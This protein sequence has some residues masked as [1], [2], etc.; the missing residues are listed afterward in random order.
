MVI[1]I[2]RA[3]IHRIHI[4][5]GFHLLQK[6][7]LS[8]VTSILFWGNVDVIILISGRIWWRRERSFKVCFINFDRFY[9][10]QVQCEAVVFT[11]VPFGRWFELWFAL[12]SWTSNK[13]RILKSYRTPDMRNATQRSTIRSWW[14]QGLRIYLILLI[15]QLNAF[16]MLSFFMNN[17]LVHCYSVIIFYVLSTAKF[18]QK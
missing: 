10:L 9:G 7:F 8:E 2:A 15:L 17:Y 1:S 16:V 13:M 4:V 5:G 18:L 6:H 11:F 3:L 14:G 12:S